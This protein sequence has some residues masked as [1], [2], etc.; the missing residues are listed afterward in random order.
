MVKVREVHSFN[1]DGSVDIQVW[2]ECIQAH[3]ELKD[4]DEI[5][6]ACELSWQLEQKAIAV[7]NTWATGGSSYRTGLEMA[8]ILAELHLDQET[9]VAA[10]LYRAVRESKLSLD[11]LEQQFGPNIAKL[12]EGVSRMAAISETETAGKP[13]FGQSDGQLENVRKMLVALVDDVRVALIKLAERTCA[14][15]AVKDASEEKRQKVAREVFDVYAPLAHRLGIGHMKWELEDLSFRY[16][17]PENY[18][19]IAQL[20]DERRIDREKFVNSIIEELRNALNAA[21]IKAEFTGRAKHIYSIWRKMQSKGID[22]SQVY[23]ARAVRVLVPTIRDCYTTFGIVNN[24]WQ[25][26]PHEFDDY[27]ATPKENGYQSLHTAVIGP[28]SKVFEI[29]IRT[30]EM[31]EEAELGVCSHW[32]YKTDG[33]KV[34]AD[35]SYEGKIAWLRQVLDWH[36]EMGRQGGFVEQLRSDGEVQDRVYV[37]TPDGHVVDLMQGAT[38]LDFAYYVHTEVGH[39]CRGAKVNGCI[40]PLNYVLQ[41]G[42][43]VEVLTAENGAP[44]RVWLASS[45][46]Y[47]KTPRTRAKIVHWFNKQNKDQN[48]QYGRSLLENEFSRLALSNISYQELAEKIDCQSEDE[49]FAAVGAGDI[50]SSTVIEAAQEVLQTFA[51]GTSAQQGE[52]D[53]LSIQAPQSAENPFNIIGTGNLKT[54]MALC[55][56]PVQGNPIVGQITPEQEVIIHRQDCSQALQLISDEDVGFIEINWGREQEK[57][58][59]VDISILAYNRAGLLRD[60]SAVLAF[61]N[62]DV[63]EVNTKTDKSSSKATMKLKIEISSLQLLSRVLIKINQVNNV[64]D[65]RRDRSASN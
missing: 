55:C 41:T 21:G 30:F 16:L 15:R 46:A 43:R 44:S 60:V 53:G 10:I 35:D 18:T 61:D 37:F 48:I 38:P 22:F 63:L 26:I 62:I 24:L 42:D 29:Q 28:D 9:I 25:F 33:K 6:A 13:V 1:E 32:R 65:V 31:D 5:L 2:L 56:Q 59:L 50:R 8:E 40:V 3:I 58:A 34:G 47:V 17:E 49:L 20:L 7:P 51:E 19:K 45:L 36:E 23:D 52:L 12:I 57:T 27:I 4:T 39:S 14:I 64:I 54:Q 11:K